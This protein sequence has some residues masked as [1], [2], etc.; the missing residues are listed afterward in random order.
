[1]HNADSHK[2]IIK[3][4]NSFNFEKLH[5]ILVEF[6]YFFLFT[7]LAVINYYVLFDFFR[8]KYLNFVDYKNLIN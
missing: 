3:I 6:F 7:P 2:I 8:N 4:K 5:L 1:M